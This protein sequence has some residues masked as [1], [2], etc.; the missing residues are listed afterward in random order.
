MLK[1][2]V[3]RVF[4]FFISLVFLVV[5]L[6]AQY[7]APESVHKWHL[8][9]DVISYLSSTLGAT[10]FVADTVGLRSLDLEKGATCYVIELASGI[11]NGGIFVVNDREHKRDGWNYFTHPDTSLE[12]A[13]YEVLN[14]SNIFRGI[15][16]GGYINGQYIKDGT[17]TK[18]DY[19]TNSIDSTIIING[20]IDSSDIK[21]GII[22][23]KKLA[24]VTITSEK[25]APG[26]IIET[27][28]AP[29]S[30]NRDAIKNGHV[31]GE[32]I[33]EETIS[34]SK[35]QD[36]SVTN[37]KIA[38]NSITGGKILDGTVYGTDLAQDVITTDKILN[39]SVMTDDIATN[40]ITSTKIKDGE[41]KSNDILD[42]AVTANKIANNAIEY[43]HYNESYFDNTIRKYF[44]GESNYYIGVKYGSTLEVLQSGLSIS[45]H[46]IKLTL[47]PEYAGGVYKKPIPG[48][49][50]VII[51]PDY[52]PVSNRNFYDIESNNEN[53]DIFDYAEFY[54]YVN[55]SEQMTS[56]NYIVITYMT[57]GGA[58]FNANIDVTVLSNT[59][60]VLFQQFD[61]Y[62]P[63]EE[64]TGFVISENEIWPFYFPILIKINAAVKLAQFVKLAEIICSYNTRY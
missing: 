43:Q 6:H 23:G 12:W 47:A 11:G 55:E 51:T 36:F 21:D 34:T 57:S 46:E 32:K 26:A 24:P 1:L 8:S 44:D 64:F 25:I 13:R 18:A 58:P 29:N 35:L 15:A 2:Q 10:P 52:D 19:A 33:E 27:H 38:N 7:I 17:I 39:G 63:T 41:V 49:D 5:P 59:G 60:Q 14:S 56:F 62:S 45:E 4:K 30:I 54:I 22:T 16:A 31:T 50:L 28:I 20:S 42:D 53:P 61:I 9:S 37:Q 48:A 3:M 40:A